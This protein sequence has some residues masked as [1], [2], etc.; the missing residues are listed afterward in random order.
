VLCDISVSHGS[1][2]DITSHIAT[3]KR[4]IYAKARDA[5]PSISSFFGGDSQMSV[6]CAETLLTGAIVEHNLPI[7]FA[8]HFG[9]ES[10]CVECVE[11]KDSLGHMQY[12]QFHYFTVWLSHLISFWFVIFECFP[13]CICLLIPPYFKLCLPPCSSLFF[14]ANLP[15]FTVDRLASLLLMFSSQYTKYVGMEYG[16]SIQLTMLDLLV[17]GLQQE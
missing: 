2:Q 13:S 8:D 11:L 1:R 10:C 5:M 4:T 14:Y 9:M 15:I 12:D 17:M 3:A 16:A 6:I 7:A